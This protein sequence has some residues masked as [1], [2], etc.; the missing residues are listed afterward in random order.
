MLLLART[1]AN[2]VV[3]LSGQ[4]A[5][6]C[7]CVADLPMDLDIGVNTEVHDL[8]HAVYQ[9]VTLSPPVIKP[10]STVAWDHPVSGA[11]RWEIAVQ[12]YTRQFAC[13]KLK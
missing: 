10:T 6:P 9:H 4:F 11:I 3:T 12:F 1:T 8:P 5:R 2:T 13:Y 7:G